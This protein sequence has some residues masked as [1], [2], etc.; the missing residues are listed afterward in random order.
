MKSYMLRRGR[1][2]NEVTLYVVTADNSDRLAKTQRVLPLVV[3]S[4]DWS[5][6]SGLY[7]VAMTILLDYFEDENDCER[8]A[9]TMSAV[10]ANRLTR[11]PRDGWRLTETD[12]N[13]LVADILVTAADRVRDCVRDTDL[14]IIEVCGSR[15][16]LVRSAALRETT[17]RLTS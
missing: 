9:V 5:A 13:D 11:L 4:D 10:F 8:R 15:R 7:G 14:M 16:D 3:G 17:S 12:V 1:R 2:F 6:S